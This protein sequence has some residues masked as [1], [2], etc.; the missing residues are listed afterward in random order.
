[1]SLEK[2]LLPTPT[3][4][5]ASNPRYYWSLSMFRTRIIIIHLG[6]CVFHALEMGKVLTTK[7]KDVSQIKSRNKRESQE[8]AQ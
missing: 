6:V 3:L 5:K 7:N 8:S 4:H 1:M 2:D